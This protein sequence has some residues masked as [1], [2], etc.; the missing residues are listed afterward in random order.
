M[1]PLCN[2]FSILATTTDSFA[3]SSSLLLLF[4]ISEHFKATG[5]Q[6]RWF[7]DLTSQVRNSKSTPML[8]QPA[9][10][11]PAIRSWDAPLRHL[12]R[13]VRRLR[14]LTFSARP[15]LEGLITYAR[16]AV[17]HQATFT[18][19]PFMNYFIKIKY[20]I[21]HLYKSRNSM[22][23]FNYFSKNS[24]SLHLWQRC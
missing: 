5:F 7:N 3:S 21:A 2:V 19:F 20:T 4:I 22:K 16:T 6:K 18:N 11:L 10:G 1:F 24:V 15:T 13:R 17:M 9:P 8:L 14:H 23:L 12:D